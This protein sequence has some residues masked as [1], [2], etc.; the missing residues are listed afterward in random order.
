MMEEPLGA[1]AYFDN[2]FS[3]AF[4]KAPFAALC[5]L[6][7]VDGMTSWDPFEESRAA[8]DDYNWMLR[9]VK[10]KRGP[11]AELRVALLMY[12]QAVEMDAAHEL[13]FNLLLTVG[14]H[15]Y[16][17]G[18]IDHLWRRNKKTGISLPPSAKTVFTA[19]R[20]LA[21]DTGETQLSQLIDG[22]FSD[23]IR[24]AFSH[25]DYVFTETSFRWSGG[26]SSLDALRTRIN[27]CF[28]FFAG[29]SNLQGQWLVGL[30]RGK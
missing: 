18:S 20:Q 17:I 21:N 7:R 4:R 9:E 25:S 11:T 23:G 29:L 28:S 2:L 5:T 24:N 8:F 1:G 14:G 6:L 19:I 15:P 10:E 26:E 13:L 16:R 3:R 22:F 27:N 12:C 30:S